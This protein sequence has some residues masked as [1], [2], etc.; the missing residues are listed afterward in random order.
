MA[1]KTAAEIEAAVESEL[2]GT[3][4]AASSLRPL[5][6]GTANFMYHARLQ[7]PLAD[8]TTEVVVKHGEGYVAQNPGFTL[9]KSRCEIEEETLRLL[10][11]LPHASTAACE[12][13]TPALLH[14][15]PETS[16]QIQEYLPDALNLKQY[17]LRHYQAPTSDGFKPQCLQ[18]GRCLGTWLRD[19]HEWS[20][21]AANHHLRE[22]FSRNG[23]MQNVKKMINYDRLLHMV[24]KYP[25]VLGGC[26]DVLMQVSDMASAELQD[27]A[28]LHVIHGDFWTGNI[29]LPDVAMDD[30]KPTPIKIV[31]WEMAQL[32]VRP[33]DLGQVIAELWQLK[34][35]KE[36]EA[37]SWIIQ[38]FVDGY[39]SVDDKFMLR[40]AVHVGAHLICIGSSTSGWGTPAQSEQVVKAGRDV[41]LK[42][43]KGDVGAFDGH[44]L[45]CLFN[46]R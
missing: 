6:G 27:P 36:I 9:T 3:P 2:K 32:G 17:A 33:L 1:I 13:G 4:F 24:A 19:F 11:R 45:A 25:S 20:E 29:L 18:L 44:D 30:G 34:L 35:Y 16:T 43:W 14:F 40:A 7:T 5:T 28:R 21:Q 39:G 41:L 26:A 38:G 46:T 22:L 42:A 8:G 37:G 23:E 15:N 12:V 10:A 31:D